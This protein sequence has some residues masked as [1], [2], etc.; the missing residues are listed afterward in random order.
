VNR[1]G[2]RAGESIV[3]YG[4]GGVGLSAVMGA[5]IAGAGKLIAVDVVDRKLEMA[6]D[7]GADH[8]VNASRENPQERVLEITGGG[9]DYSM[10]TV[11]NV[12]VIA[13][14]FGSI[15]SSGTCVL[16]GVPPLGD[17]L[18]LAPY[19]FLLGKKLIG[20]YLGNVRTRVDVPRYIDLYVNGQLPIEKLITR[21]YSLDEI[22]EAFEALEKGEVIRGVIRF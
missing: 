2:L 3:I 1:A 4:C 7:L 13:Q 16:V 9:A 18:N 14:A 6:K 8:V 17:M 19:E 21:Y 10:D 11:G 15:H 20:S 12:Q 22:N 5:K